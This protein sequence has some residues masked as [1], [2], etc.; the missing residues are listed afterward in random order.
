M[1]EARI[2]LAEVIVALRR[3][4]AEAQVQDQ[5]LRPGLRIEEAEIELQVIITRQDGVD[6]HV[7]FW[8]LNANVKDKSASATAQKIKIRLKSI[9]SDGVDVLIAKEYGSEEG[10]TSIRDTIKPPPPLSRRRRSIE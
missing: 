1:A 7:K 9:E 8:V 2:P 3:E 4:L 10:E 5:G 6:F